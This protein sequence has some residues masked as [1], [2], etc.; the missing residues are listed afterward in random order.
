MKIHTDPQRSDAWFKR[1]LGVPTASKFDRIITPQGKRSDQ[2]R[3]LMYELAYETISGKLTDRDLSNVPHVKFGIDNEPVAVKAFEQHTGLRTEDIGF[4][5][6]D[7]ETIGCSPDRV[8]VGRNEALEV[9]CPMGPTVCGYLIDGMLNA[10]RAQI[11]GQILIGGFTCV[12]FYA[13]SGELPPYYEIVTPD[14]EFLRSLQ[15]YLSEFRTE[16]IAGITHIR[17]LGSWPSNAPSV[18]PDESPPA[19]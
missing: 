3:K 17:S 4:I 1:R 6:D 19:A 13:W 16:L 14:L 10:Y 15:Q 9:K 2:A 7:S 11:Q 5:T 12:H 8:I 18:F